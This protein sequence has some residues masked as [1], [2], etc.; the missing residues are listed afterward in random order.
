MRGKLLDKAKAQGPLVQASREAPEE[1][2]RQEM[3]QTY[4]DVKREE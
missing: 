1:D 4:Q 2:I 3:E